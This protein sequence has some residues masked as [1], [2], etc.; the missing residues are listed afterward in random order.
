MV[1][2]SEFRNGLVLLL[3]GDLFT[4][5]EGERF[6]LVIFNPPYY[7]GRPKDW[8][9]YAWRGDEVLKR[10]TEGI[11]SHLVQNGRVLLSLST[12]MNLVAVK[13]ELDRNGFEMRESRRRRLVGETI[14]VYECG[15]SLALAHSRGEATPGVG[16]R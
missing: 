13:A 7:E 2:T 8:P 1:S 15:S 11:P 10:F 3:E 12:E 9:E 16:S 5:V 4:P 6:D 14:F